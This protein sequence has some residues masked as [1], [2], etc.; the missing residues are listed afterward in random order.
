MPIPTPQP[1]VEPIIQPE[2]PKEPVTPRL[3]FSAELASQ[4]ETIGKTFSKRPIS[5][6]AKRLKSHLENMREDLLGAP[7]PVREVADNYEANDQEIKNEEEEQARIADDIHKIA[8][9]FK[10]RMAATTNLLNEDNK[11]IDKGAKVIDKNIDNLKKVDTKLGAHRSTL[12]MNLFTTLN[13]ILMVFVVF[14]SMVVIIKI[15][16]K[17]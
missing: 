10:G 16:P 6:H 3:S 1:I 7:S 17:R 12:S 15:F 8:A 9:D 13:M 11:V 4:F 2:P 5:F 14:F